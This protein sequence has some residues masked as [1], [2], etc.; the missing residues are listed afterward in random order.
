MAEFVLGCVQLGLAYGVANRGGKPSR[1]AALALLERA[2]AGG[3]HTFD[4]ARAYG[5]AEERLGEVLSGKDVAIVTKLSPLSE[6]A[7]ADSSG[8][9]VVAAESSVAHSREALGRN[10]L[11]CL[12]LHRAAHR[13]A[14][15]GAVWQRLKK[16]QAEGVIG[17]LGVSVQ[18]PQEAREALSDPAVGHI[19]LPFN[20]LDRRWDDVL[21]GIRPDVTVHVRSVFL[22][23]LLA[24][25]E[26][27]LWPKIDGI[28][29]PAIVAQIAHLAR[30]LDRDSPADLCLAFVRGHRALHGI[31][32]GLETIAQLD[33][34][35]ALF[36]RPPLTQEEMAMV[37]SRLPHLP[38]QLLNPALWPKS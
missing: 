36:A 32:I 9:A 26:A 7:E 38:E 29:A 17:R 14:F 21:C 2:L 28:D 11:D 6:V 30:A 34:N 10:R 37:R 4:V 22:Q 23:G 1:A 12:L 5:D 18:D 8:R 31:V 3:I 19:Q 33:C 16:F 27:S 20:L 25:N 13:T 15:G 24:A 35:L